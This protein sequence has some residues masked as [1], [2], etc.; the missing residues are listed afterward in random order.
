MAGSGSAVTTLHRSRG[1]VRV[2]VTLTPDASGVVTGFDT[3]DLFGRLVDVYL[4]G[5]AATPVITLTD[6]ISSVPL[7][8]LTASGSADRKHARLAQLQSLTTSTF[9]TQITPASTATDVYEDLY[10]AGPITVS[11]TAGGN[12]L[13]SVL[14]L[15]VDEGLNQ[16]SVGITR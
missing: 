15:I 13:V 10:V 4:K 2:D 6:K 5:A 1:I 7:A 9:G 16:K 8:V 3:P 11:M 14:T 12:T